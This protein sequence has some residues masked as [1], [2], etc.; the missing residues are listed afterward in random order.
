MP[1]SARPTSVLRSARTLSVTALTLTMGLSILPVQAAEGIV[2]KVRQPQANAS[3]IAWLRPEA[4][5]HPNIVKAKA[6]ARALAGK[7]FLG[8]GSYICSASGFGKKSH[9]F[10]R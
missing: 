5:K 8:R 4:K 10:A 6:E 9:C 7:G 3:V 1:R 2:S